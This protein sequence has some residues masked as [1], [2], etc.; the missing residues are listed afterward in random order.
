MAC[1]KS[2]QRYADHNIMIYYPF[3]IIKSFG[4]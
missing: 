1:L 3:W 4:S 2:E